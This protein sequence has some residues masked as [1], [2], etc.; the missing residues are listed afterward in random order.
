MVMC[1]Q[2]ITGRTRHGRFAS[3]LASETTCRPRTN[4][5]PAHLDQDAGLTSLNKLEYHLLEETANYYIQILPRSFVLS[6]FLLFGQQ[7]L[8]FRQCTSSYSFLI[9]ATEIFG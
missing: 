8:A 5:L 9:S 4:T 2:Y 7:R 1:Y 3:Q 6:E